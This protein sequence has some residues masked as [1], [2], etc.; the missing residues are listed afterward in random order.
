MNLIEIVRR[1]ILYG[2]CKL[3]LSDSGNDLIARFTVYAFYKT[4][5]NTTSIEMAVYCIRTSS[6]ATLFL[7]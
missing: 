3:K 4:T 2:Y 6:G 7:Q 5:L 1:I